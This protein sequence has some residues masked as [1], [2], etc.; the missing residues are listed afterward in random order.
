MGGTRVH[1]ATLRGEAT[2]ELGITMVADLKSLAWRTI[3]NG[4][5][6]ASGLP[7][8]SGTFGPTVRACPRDSGVAAR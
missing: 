7:L 8:T 1:T 6:M 2:I 5:L 3:T 4:V